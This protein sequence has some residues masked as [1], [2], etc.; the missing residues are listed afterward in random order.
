[1]SLRAPQPILPSQPKVICLLPFPQKP[2]GNTFISAMP[3]IATSNRMS[4]R[5]HSLPNCSTSPMSGIG[6]KGEVDAHVLLGFDPSRCCSRLAALR[7][8]V[9]EPL[10]AS[11]RA[12]PAYLSPV[13]FGPR[14]LDREN[15]AKLAPRAGGLAVMGR[16]RGRCRHAAARRAAHG[17]AGRHRCPARS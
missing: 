16:R 17:R 10:F 15:P 8:E 14:I 7:T 2:S 5:G 12:C 13:A 11:L 6:L 9:I 3:S 1:M 4:V